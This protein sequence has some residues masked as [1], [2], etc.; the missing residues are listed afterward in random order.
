MKSGRSTRKPA[1]RAKARRA[2]VKTA[3]GSARPLPAEPS[4]V[5]TVR[6]PQ[7]AGLKLEASCTLRDALDLQFQL[8]AT[9]FGDADVVLDGSCVERIDT[10]GLQL[11]VAFARHHAQ[12][13]KQLQ[14]TAASP[15]LLRGSRLLG[16]AQLLGLP[17]APTAGEAGGH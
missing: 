8:L 7:R 6:A 10:A 9:D 17:S 11:L 4:S 15:E 2:P 12:H 1:A 13:G 14:W 16:L 3:E 5:V